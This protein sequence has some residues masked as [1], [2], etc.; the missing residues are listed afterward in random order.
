MWALITPLAPCPAAVCMHDTSMSRTHVIID[1]NWQDFR[2][3]TEEAH[4]WLAI[5]LQHM[6]TT[7]LL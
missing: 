7:L 6:E 4:A 2:A 3:L 5:V 1:S